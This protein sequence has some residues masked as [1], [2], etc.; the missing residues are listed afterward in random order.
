[1]SPSIVLGVPVSWEQTARG[2]QSTKY[3]LEN[4]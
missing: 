4:D 2:S 3:S 1:M